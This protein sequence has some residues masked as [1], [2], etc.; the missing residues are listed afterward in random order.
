MAAKKA[1][2]AKNLAKAKEFKNLGKNA[3]L[4]AKKCKN[5]ARELRV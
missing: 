4:M 5:I 2:K 1:S 3:E